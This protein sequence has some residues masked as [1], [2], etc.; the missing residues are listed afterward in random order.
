MA[1]TVER[2]G[3]TGESE[4]AAVV[5]LMCCREE[6]GVAPHPP[7]TGNPATKRN[8][9]LHGAQGTIKGEKPANEG[10]YKK[11]ILVKKT[12]RQSWKKRKTEKVAQRRAHESLIEVKSGKDKQILAWN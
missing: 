5:G 10:C 2:R 1:S 6:S 8:G 12:L 7:A 9:T 4:A 3:W 11:E